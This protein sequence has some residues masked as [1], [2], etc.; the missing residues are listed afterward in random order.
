MCGHNQILKAEV[1]LQ[2]NTVLLFMIIQKLNGN[3]SF[4]LCAVLFGFE[5]FLLIVLTFSKFS[6]K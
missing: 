1:Y 6:C 5:V 4:I 2:I 3:S